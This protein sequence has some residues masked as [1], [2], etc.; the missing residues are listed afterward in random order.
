M[1]Y[2][3]GKVMQQEL[4]STWKGFFYTARG[5]FSEKTFT[6]FV[7]PQR[8]YQHKTCHH[9]ALLELKN[10]RFTPLAS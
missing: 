2:I 3:I 9:L 7:E 1:T 5:I 6:N 10:L 8:I 4:E